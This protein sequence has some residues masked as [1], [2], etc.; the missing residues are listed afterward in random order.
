[1]CIRDRQVCQ[2]GEVIE[3]T[4]GKQDRGNCDLFC[5]DYLKRIM[6]VKGWIEEDAFPARF[7]LQDDDVIFQRT[8]NLQV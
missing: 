5:I 4:M 2:A 7:I 6:Q 1:M 8:T 3:V